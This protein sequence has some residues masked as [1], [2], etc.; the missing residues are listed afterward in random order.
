MYVGSNLLLLRRLDFHFTTSYAYLQPQEV[1]DQKRSAYVE[2][3]LVVSLYTDRAD[4]PHSV[5]SA[6]SASSNPSC[7][8]L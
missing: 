5:G 1:C 8:A 4:P 6:I 7:C 2:E 3:V